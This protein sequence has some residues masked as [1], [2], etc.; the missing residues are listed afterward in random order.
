MSMR[1]N[2]VNILTY[3]SPERIGSKLICRSS[4]MHMFTRKMQQHG[5]RTAEPW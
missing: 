3:S 2:D 4:N 5:I 1:Q